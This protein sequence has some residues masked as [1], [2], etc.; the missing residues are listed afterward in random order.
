MKDG[1][2]DMARPKIG[3]FVNQVKAEAGKIVWPT[4]RETMQ[5]TIMVLIMTILLSLFF[6]GVDTGFK[7][8]VG[9]LT[10]LAG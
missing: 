7:L 2:I 10:S 1:T 9:W 3:E 8:I 5:T 4:G 6:F